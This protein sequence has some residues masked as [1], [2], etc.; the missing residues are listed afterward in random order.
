MSSKHSY[1]D[2]TS[3]FSPL[4]T[5]SRIN[6][7]D[8]NVKTRY[9]EVKR[10]GWEYCI[11][12]SIHGERYCGVYTKV[13]ILPSIKVNDITYSLRVHCNFCHSEDCVHASFAYTLYNT[14]GLHPSEEVDVEQDS[15]RY[16]CE[17]RR[18]VLAKS[19][20]NYISKENIN[21]KNSITL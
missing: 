10:S 5:L 14:F 12:H 13:T 6:L 15:I 11:S 2:S 1:P 21:Q 8:V 20:S 7:G 16:D 18:V 4:P 9:D 17:K 3:K 19:Y